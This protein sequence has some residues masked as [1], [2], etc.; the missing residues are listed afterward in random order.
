MCGELA[1]DGS[2]GEVQVRAAEVLLPVNEEDLLLEA[3]V[4]RESPGGGGGVAQLVQQVAVV[5]TR[6]AVGAE[7]WG[8]LGKGLVVVDDEDAGMLMTPLGRKMGGRCP[9]RGTHRRCRCR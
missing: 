8:L 5:L 1:H 9:G 7:D 4:G 6:G 2:P 3:G